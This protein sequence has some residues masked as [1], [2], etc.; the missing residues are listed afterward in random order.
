[1]RSKRWKSMRIGVRK[2]RPK[3]ASVGIETGEWKSRGIGVKRRRSKS[4]RMDE[5]K[6]VE[7]HKN[8]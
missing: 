2:R 1:V 3:C 6:V 7:I 4:T 5:E 8:G